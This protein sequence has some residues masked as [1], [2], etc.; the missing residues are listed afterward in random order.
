MPIENENDNKKKP[1]E[2]DDDK[3]P[4]AETILETSKDPD[5]AVIAEQAIR[6]FTADRLAEWY[7]GMESAI[8]NFEAWLHSQ[9]Q[10][11]KGHF[12]QRGFFDSLGDRYRYEL[13]EIAGGKGTPIMD[14]IAAETDNTV[15]WA[16]HTE[17]DLFQFV[18][19]MRRGLRDACW[20]V[21][22]C[23][24]TIVSNQWPQLLDLAYGGSLEF[25]PALLHLG[26]PSI[27]YKPQQFTDKL[28]QHATSFRRA[29]EPAKE[30]VA[31]NT[32]A[33]DGK[34]SEVEQEEKQV[35]QDDEL[36]RKTVD[37][38]QSTMTA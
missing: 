33:D 26:L 11:S 2:G 30:Q 18:N 12:A 36:K 7:A 38:S 20:F 23:L 27:N 29:F 9:D 21:R 37:Q 28:V 24:P 15:S 32:K 35:L 25:V 34:K 19:Y 5:Q 31:E 10:E 14:A 13:T 16:E 1:G 8:D 17:S 4:V 6:G 22:D 3:P